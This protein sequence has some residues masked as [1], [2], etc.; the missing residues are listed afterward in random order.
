MDSGKA[1]GGEMKMALV[2]SAGLVMMGVWPDRA[3]AQ[4]PA[5]LATDSVNVR[6]R[7]DAK[8][9]APGGASAP[10]KAA[11]TTLQPDALPRLPQ[12][13]ADSGQASTLR[14]APPP[15]PPRTAPAP[16]KGRG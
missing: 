16:K 8:R 3:D 2:L 4:G 7:T 10:A 1:G 12:S 5:S 9:K 11:P 15:V 14:N 6:L 13:A